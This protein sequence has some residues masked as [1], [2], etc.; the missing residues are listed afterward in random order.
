MV[1]VRVCVHVSGCTAHA[2]YHLLLACSTCTGDTVFAVLLCC[3]ANLQYR[4]YAVQ[5]VQLQWALVS[6]GVH[7]YC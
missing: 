3:T 7:V 1:S 2:M 4:K 5:A 6:H